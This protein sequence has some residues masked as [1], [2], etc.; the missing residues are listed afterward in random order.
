MSTVGST[1]IVSGVV[2]ATRGIQTH[3]LATGQIWPAMSTSWS[4]AGAS[5][6]PSN[7]ANGDVRV[8]KARD[9]ARLFNRS[10]SWFHQQRSNLEQE[11]FPARDTLLGG[12]PRLAVERW[13]DGRDDKTAGTRVTP[14]AWSVGLAGKE[15]DHARRH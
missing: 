11:G 15:L 1:A 8:L 13:F 6:I 10:V 7:R 2:S 5:A 14:P 9:V 12:W 4:K 3:E